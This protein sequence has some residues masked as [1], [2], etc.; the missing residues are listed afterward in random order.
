MENPRYLVTVVIDDAEIESG[1][2]YGSKVALPIFYEIA[3]V[4][5]QRST[6]K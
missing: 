3:K 4:L 6:V 5:L 2:A 1:V